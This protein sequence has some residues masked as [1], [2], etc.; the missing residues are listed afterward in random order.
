[1]TT[2]QNDL[3]IRPISGREEP[4]LFSRQPYVLN[5]ELADDLDHARR[6]VRRCGGR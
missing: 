3:T 1:M 4:D 5:E 2:E 6:P